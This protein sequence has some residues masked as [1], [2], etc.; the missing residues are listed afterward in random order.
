MLNKEEAAKHNRKVA[1]LREKAL[2]ERLYCSTDEN[3]NALKTT[4]GGTRSVLPMCKPETRRF[5]APVTGKPIKLRM[6]NVSSK[7]GKELGAI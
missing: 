7:F 2:Y 3:G 1:F 6:S 5:N 4:Q